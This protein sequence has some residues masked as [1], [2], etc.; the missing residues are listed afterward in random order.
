[1]PMRRKTD[2]N[3]DGAANLYDLSLFAGHYSSSVGSERFDK[4]CDF[5][6]DE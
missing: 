1:M 6:N 4:K 2:L 5:D 3:C